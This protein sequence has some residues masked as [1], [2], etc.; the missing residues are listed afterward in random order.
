MFGP[1][2]QTLRS[3]LGGFDHDAHD[4][5]DTAVEAGRA[6]GVMSIQQDPLSME[7]TVIGQRASIWSALRFT[8]EFPCD[9]NGRQLRVEVP[10]GPSDE[11][12]REDDLAKRLFADGVRVH[13]LFSEPRV[14]LS[15]PSG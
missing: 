10:L 14:E 4:P 15:L 13:G 1:S 2:R 12:Q 5:T 11:H 6:A 7:Q 3:N 8:R 9:A